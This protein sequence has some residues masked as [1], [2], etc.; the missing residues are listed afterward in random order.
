MNRNV[1]S[2]LSLKLIRWTSIL[3]VTAAMIGLYL[4]GA[5]RQFTE[6][7]SGP[8]LIDQDAYMEYAKKIYKFEFRYPFERNRMPLYPSFQ[9]LFFDVSETRREFFEAGAWRNAYLSIFLLAGIAWLFRRHFSLFSTFIAVLI[10]GFTVFVFKAAWFQAELLFYFLTF[11]MFYLML[12]LF[13]RPHWT[14]AV[15][16][17]VVAGLAHLTKASVLP[18]LLLFMVF[19]FAQGIWR[20]VQRRRATGESGQG[21]RATSGMWLAPLVGLV[22][23]AI[24]F[25]YIRT[26]KI[27]FGQ[28]FYNV[29][30]TFYIWYDSWE[31]ASLGTKAHGD[32]EG[33]PDMPA[34]EIPSMG[35]YLGEHTPEQIGLRLVNGAQ[36]VL[37]N[38]IH[39]YGY[40][41]YLVL[42][43][44]LGLAGMIWERRRAVEWAQRNGFLI[45]FVLAYFG[46]YF[47]LYAWY[48]PIAEGNRLILAQFLP[49]LFVL[50]S[51]VHGLLGDKVVKVFDRPVQVL[52]GINWAMLAILGVDIYLILTQRIGL[53]LGG[54]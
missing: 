7:N 40:F 16:A 39:S 22:F 36:L 49:L 28:Y 37:D 18:G 25:P 52:S 47:L 3:A 42:Y 43:A 34:D 12:A 4:Y 23:L 29:N 32:R 19:F 1:H 13:R 38:V 48:A 20:Y 44:L 51:A 46:A 14:I 50:F 27:H 11:G 2:A 26:S 53:I 30:S 33:W 9:A 6:M 24:I 17:G 8:G 41:K 15:L 45:L 21:L 54:K 5:G 10:T 31:E 35:K